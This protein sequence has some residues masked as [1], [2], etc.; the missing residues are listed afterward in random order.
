MT[1]CVA[2]EDDLNPT[3]D[4]QWCRIA[5]HIQLQ[6]KPPGTRPPV[7]EESAQ[8][9]KGK[10]QTETDT[11]RRAEW[12]QRNG[13]EKAGKL[14]AFTAKSSLLHKDTPGTA[15]KQTSQLFAAECQSN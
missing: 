6:L 1:E 8:V 14:N 10:E 5:S 4:S 15:M 11:L 7:P 12:H 2:L 13:E 9:C 3:K